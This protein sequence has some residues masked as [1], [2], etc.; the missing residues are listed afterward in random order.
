MIGYKST[1]TRSF[2]FWGAVIISVGLVRL[3][4]YWLDRKSIPIRYKS[5]PMHE[6]EVHLLVLFPSYFLLIHEK[7]VLVVGKDKHYEISEVEELAYMT[8]CVSF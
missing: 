1:F 3:L 5:C 6:A 4:A 7:R 2:F 8:R